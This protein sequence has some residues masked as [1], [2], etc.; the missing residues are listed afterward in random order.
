MT[1][2]KEP[3]SIPKPIFLGF[4]LKEKW[5]LLGGEFGD[6][7]NSDNNHIEEICSTGDCN[8]KRPHGW[9]ERWDFNNASCWNDESSAEACVS[10]QE[11]SGYCLYAYRVIPLEFGKDGAPRQLGIGEL[12]LDGL[13]DLP[14]ER[15]LTDYE[16]LGYDIVEHVGSL[17]YGCSP[18]S[19][20]GEHNRYPVNKYCLLPDLHTAIAAATAFGLEEPEPGP[21]IIIEVFRKC[22]QV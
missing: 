8:I 9:V 20:N 17:G 15:E 11:R 19:C 22:G 14:I 2:V 12:F 18:L 1:H 10:L 21:Y 5:S 6:W 13:G 3:P 16:W 7:R 4:L